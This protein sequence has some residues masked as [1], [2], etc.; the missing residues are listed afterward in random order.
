MLPPPGQ[1]T[2][3]T[4]T[5]PFD[6]MFP[7]RFVGGKPRLGSAGAASGRLFRPDTRQ[8][9]GTP[10][11]LKVGAQEGGKIRRR[12]LRWAGQFDAQLLT[13]FVELVL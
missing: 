1:R 2:T 6:M 8:L 10:G 5:L 7:P 13:V 12:G 4:K 9:H 11:T 3:P